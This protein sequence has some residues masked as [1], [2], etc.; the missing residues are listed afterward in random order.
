MGELYVCIVAIYIMPNYEV[1]MWRTLLLYC[2]IPVII[3]TVS[4]YFVMESGRFLL[5]NRR[6]DEA[7]TFFFKL[8]EIA[9]IPFNDTKMNE[10]EKECIQ[11]PVS[12][13]ESTFSMLLNKRFLKLSLLTWVIWFVFSFALYGTIYM[14]PQI[15]DYVPEIQAAKSGTMFKN[16]IIS[17]LI[18]LPKS[19]LSGFLSNI[20]FLGRKFSM[21]YSFIVMAIFELLLIIDIKHVHIY[22]GFVKLLSGLIA[23]IV[24]VYSTEAYPTKIRGIG[25]GTGNSMSRLSGCLV[26][27]MCEFLISLFGILGPCYFILIISLISAYCSFKLPFETL[28]RELDKCDIEDI[29]EIKEME[30][31]IK[32]EQQKVINYA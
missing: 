29:K 8:A 21:L 27:F 11:N 12:K 4:S 7:R 2:L 19:L 17:N 22:S 24:K 31:E 3:C 13:Y 18:S 1:D 10:I 30:M 23:G 15:L 9:N 26:P 16:V 14:L 5:A 32:T 25:Y 28:G 20:T 6:F